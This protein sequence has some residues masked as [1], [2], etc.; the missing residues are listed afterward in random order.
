M[1]TAAGGVLDQGSY[2]YLEDE[3]P[4]VPGTIDVFTVDP[5]NT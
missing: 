3:Y 5:E 4:F 2:E 1:L